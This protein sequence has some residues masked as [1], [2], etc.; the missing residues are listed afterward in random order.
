MPPLL[1]L[2]D[3][4]CHIGHWFGAASRENY[5]NKCVYL[6]LVNSD[7]R[8]KYCF[9]ASGKYFQEIGKLQFVR[10]AHFKKTC[11]MQVR[12]K[13]EKPEHQLCHPD[14]V[15]SGG[16]SSTFKACSLSSKWKKQTESFVPW[17]VRE[18][19]WNASRVRV[20]LQHIPSPFSQ[21]VPKTPLFFM[22]SMCTLCVCV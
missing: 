21:V 12:Y 7:V 9:A 14:S 2:I 8:N 19:R 10:R 1:L 16:N 15:L 4:P 18:S 22:F 6:T 17:L 13:G 3:S 11:V 5:Y 20:G